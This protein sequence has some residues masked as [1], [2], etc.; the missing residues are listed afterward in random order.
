MP[1]RPEGRDP[2]SQNDNLP[3]DVRDRIPD[4]RDGLTRV[5]RIVIWQLGVLEKERNGR[6]VPT[7][8]LYG[9]VVEYV[10]ITERELS[11]I[12]ARLG[13]RK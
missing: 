6:M 5:E 8:Q 7:A 12:L 3:A 13:A 4:V 10:D 1:R 11:A 2:A 9:R